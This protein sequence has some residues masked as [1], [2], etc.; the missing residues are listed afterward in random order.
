[1]MAP[2]L[3]AYL[4]S[5]FIKMRDE[6]YFAA[7]GC[8]WSRLRVIGESP[9]LYQHQLQHGREDTRSMAAGRAL[10]AALLEPERYADPHQWAVYPGQRRGK[11]FEMFKRAYPNAHIRTQ[12]EADVVACQVQA[13]HKHRDAGYLLRCPAYMERVA[14][15]HGDGRLNKAKIDALIPFGDWRLVLVDLKT[16]R[17]VEPSK[18]QASAEEFGYFGQLAHYATGIETLTGVTP[19]VFIMAVENT[20]PYDVGLFH[21]TPETLENGRRQRASLLSTLAQCE[22]TDVWPGRVAEL[23]TLERPRWSKHHTVPFS[24]E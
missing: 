1:M 2:L 6:D 15:W 22:A 18:F 14:F 8:N 10:H 11:A 3:Q 9:L 13:L 24:L 23:T 16:T 21:I 7:P 19:I 12:A 4:E 20:P 17:S 5:R